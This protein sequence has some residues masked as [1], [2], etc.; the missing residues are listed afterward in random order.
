MEL[1]KSPVITLEKSLNK[2]V[3]ISLKN[4]FQIEGTLQSFDKFN[5]MMLKKAI[6]IEKNTKKELGEIYINGHNLIS[7][8]QLEI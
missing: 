7:I 2:K 4:N 1:S 3:K 8:T 6:Q 5:N